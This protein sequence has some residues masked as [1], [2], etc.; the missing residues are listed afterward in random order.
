MKQ[1]WSIII[2]AYNEENSIGR[3]IDK[4]VEVLKKISGEIF[5]LIIVN[6]GSTD[7]T[8]REIQNRAKKNS[9][10]IV[11][12]HEKNLGIGQ[13]QM[14]GY[15]MAHYENV[16][17][18]PG[19]GQ[20]N[21]NELTPYSNFPDKTIV[22]FYRIEK[23]RYTVFRKLLSWANRVLNHKLLGIKLRD[24]NWV[25]VYK[26]SFFDSIKPVLTS[27]LVESEICAKMLKKGYTVIEVPSKYHPRTGGKSKG[28]SLKTI[29]KVLVEI[30]KLYL[31]LKCRKK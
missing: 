13:S 23:T 31:I 19:D 24:V 11:I 17:A 5:E 9:K 7:S 8:F 28:A 27:A 22:S 6:D 1:S 30:S 16:C 21:P 26:R 15:N 25:K 14:S 10:I 18:I 4:S 20:F 3:V 12:N 2:F 29:V